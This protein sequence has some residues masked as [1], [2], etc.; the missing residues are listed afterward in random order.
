MVGQLQFPAILRVQKGME[1]VAD[2]QEA[3]RATF[4]TFAVEHQIQFAIPVTPTTETEPL[5]SRALAYRFTNEQETWSALLAPTALTLEA[6]AG[7]RYSSYS[8]FSELFARLWEA[9]VEHLRP[10][11][12]ARQGL[13]YID[14]LEGERSPAEWTEWINPALL[15]ALG[16]DVLDAE[17]LE[18]AVSEVV[19]ADGTDR[20]VFR[21]GLA[22]AGPQSAKGYL[23]DFDAIHGEPLEPDDLDAM[24]RRFDE[25][26][27]LLYRFFRWC[28]T[29]RALEEFRNVGD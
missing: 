7:G 29:D 18:R 25:S 9:A 12:I 2:F 10:T 4:P 15:G 20:L 26:H 1:A 3:I 21:H 19:Y 8:V 28:V 6:V 14:H 22:P 24:R 27:E 5:T 13:R 16:G 23:L 17:H 11:K